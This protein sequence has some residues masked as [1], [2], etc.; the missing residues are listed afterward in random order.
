MSKTKGRRKPNTVNV[1]L[2]R[3]RRYEKGGKVK[4]K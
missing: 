1:G 4:K 2:S 3:G